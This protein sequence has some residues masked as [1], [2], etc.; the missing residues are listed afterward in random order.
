MSTTYI[1][2][3]DGYEMIE[4]APHRFVNAPAAIKLGLVAR[5]AVVRAPDPDKVTHVVPKLRAA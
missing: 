3:T 1:R 4:I 2:S 5:E